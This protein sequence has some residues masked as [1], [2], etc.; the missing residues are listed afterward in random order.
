M[1]FNEELETALAAFVQESGLDREEAIQRILREWLVR[2]G[3]LFSGQEGIRPEK[4][5]ASNDD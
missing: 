2:E 3:F 4:L 5:N 1:I